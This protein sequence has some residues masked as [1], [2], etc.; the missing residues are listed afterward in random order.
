VQHFLLGR[1]HVFA[2]ACPIDESATVFTHELEIRVRS[3]C[4]ISDANRHAYQQWANERDDHGIEREWKW[5]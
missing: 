5:I 4:P 1:F 3:C 2:I